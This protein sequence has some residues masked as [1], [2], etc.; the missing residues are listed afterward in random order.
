MCVSL[1][2]VAT[3]FTNSAD[4]MDGQGSAAYAA[5]GL[6]LAGTIASTIASTLSSVP[7]TYLQLINRAPARANAQIENASINEKEL[8]TTSAQLVGPQDGLIKVMQ[9]ILKLEGGPKAFIKGLL[10]TVL[11]GLVAAG[12]TVLPLAVLEQ[13]IFERHNTRR[14]LLLTSGIRL[15][16]MLGIQSAVVTP[17]EILNVRLM[18]Q[19]VTRTLK[20]EAKYLWLRLG[21]TEWFS[22]AVLGPTLL[23]NAICVVIGLVTQLATGMPSQVLRTG[24]TEVLAAIISTV[25][26]HVLTY[27]VLRARNLAAA[28]LR[29]LEEPV[30]PVATYGGLGDEI[31]RDEAWQGFVP[32]M[33]VLL[34]TKLPVLLLQLA[35]GMPSST[36]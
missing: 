20:Q 11:G 28:T 12:V 10:P 25:A 36:F 9:N 35:Q 17:F 30:I 2:C 23:S 3:T 29:P 26:V 6:G 13:N 22:S 34:F 21:Y 16:L 27:P 19:S 18:L 15:F 33:Q 1:R 8:Q 24:R 5:I 7:V 32:V 14:W 4:V 31:V